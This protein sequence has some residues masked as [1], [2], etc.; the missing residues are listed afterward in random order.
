MGLGRVN[1]GRLLWETARRF[2][3]SLLTP[4]PFL[5]L[6]LR[7]TT[8][9]WIDLVDNTSFKPEFGPSISSGRVRSSLSRVEVPEPFARFG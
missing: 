5:N 1:L 7:A 8:L 9:I 4:P 6:P 2:T 3:H